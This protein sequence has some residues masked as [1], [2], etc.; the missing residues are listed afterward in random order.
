M[1]VLDSCW[2]NVAVIQLPTLPKMS[3][4]RRRRMLTQ[5][6]LAA[7]SGVS[8]GTIARI[9]SGQRTDLRFG[10]MRKLASALGVEPSDVTEF[11]P[12]LGLNG[13]T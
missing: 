6:G 5:H 12:S 13:D 2:G 11:R 9:E 4:L 7:Q 3:L 10:T 1:L 8:Q